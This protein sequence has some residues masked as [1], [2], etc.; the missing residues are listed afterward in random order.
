MGN[1]SRRKER[2]IREPKKI[3]LSVNKKNLIIRAIIAVVCLFLGAFLIAHSCSKNNDN[4]SGYI[5]IKYP[6][7]ENSEKENE[8]LF[9]NNIKINYY[10]VENEEIDSELVN[11]KINNLLNDMIKYHK[12]FDCDDL[13]FNNDEYLHNLKYIDNHPNEWIEIDSILYDSLKNADNLSKLTDGKY[14]IFSGKLYEIWASIIDDYHMYGAN[15]TAIHSIDPMYNDYYREQISTIVNSINNA[16]TYFEF[17]DATKEV[18]YNVLENDK[19]NIVLDFGFYEYAYVI[20]YMKA[21]LVSEKLTS[22]TITSS[23]GMVATLGDNYEK[24]YHQINSVSF[25]SIYNN[26]LVYDYSFAYY[27]KSNG[28]MFNPLLDFKLHSYL[29]NKTAYYYFFDGNNIIIRSL[30]LNSK[31]GYSDFSVHSSFIF[32]SE[33]SLCDQLVG[34]Y[35]LYFNEDGDYGYNY[36]LKYQNDEKTGAIVIFNNGNTNI[37]INNATTLLY[38]TLM[39]NYFEEGYIP[40]IKLSDFIKSKIEVTKGE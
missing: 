18:R 29:N 3:I 33:K 39:A 20:D 30:L 1:V 25:Q 27:G 17:N 4:N 32:S 26:S 34:N 19:E 16:S 35:N 13:Y 7:F 15:N 40:Y 38:S 8:V 23:S 2:K 12:L 31:T 21:I 36:L 14:S 22:C 5:N 24:G 37:G 10:Y 28:M 11:E 9:D 6:N